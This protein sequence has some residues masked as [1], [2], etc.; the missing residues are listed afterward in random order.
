[1][2]WLVMR[3]PAGTNRADTQ[4]RYMAEPLATARVEFSI[5]SSHGRAG[6]PEVEAFFSALMPSM[7]TFLPMA[8]IGG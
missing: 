7:N 6:A 3:I 1:M 2:E 5:P 8:N 4:V